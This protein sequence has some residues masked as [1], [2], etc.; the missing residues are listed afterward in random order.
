MALRCVRDTRRQLCYQAADM[1][2]KH[3]R[4][5]EGERIA[6][7][8]ARAGLASRREA[9]A[10]IAAGRVAVNGAVIASPALNITASDHVTIDGQPLPGRERTR[11]FL[12]HKPRGF[13]TTHSDPQGRPTVFSSLPKHLPRFISIGRLDANTEGLLLLTNDGGLARLLELPATGWTR[14]YRVR[15]NGK[16]AQE[17]LD[18]LRHGIEIDGVRYGA[19]EARLDREQG[20]NVW[21]SFAMREGKNR[22]IK[23]VLGHFGLA[24]N[25]LIRVSFG[26]FQL[27]DLSPG[28]VEEVRTRHLREQLGEKL[29]AAAGLDFAGPLLVPAPQGRGGEDRRSELGGVGLARTMRS[30]PD[31]SHALAASFPVR[32]KDKKPGRKQDA[33]NPGRGSR[34]KKQRRPPPE[35]VGEPERARRERKR[36]RRPF[37]G[38]P[39]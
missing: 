18:R 12:F 4:P 11:L 23:N 13:V 16:I 5:A 38:K 22:E 8:I 21:L 2:G 10:W 19:I 27:G 7:A 37:R 25:R 29:V 14:R 30:P 17:R 36:A 24:V 3:D 9:E 20:A 31:R 35:H 32:G 28:A 6:K 33:S 15:A 1:T 34:H 39:G 26:P